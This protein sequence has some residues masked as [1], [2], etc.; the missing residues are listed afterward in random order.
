MVR[1]SDKAWSSL[2]IFENSLEL[3]VTREEYSVSGIER[4]STSREMRL[5]LNSVDL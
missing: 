2:Q 5:R 4:C 1:D 3:M